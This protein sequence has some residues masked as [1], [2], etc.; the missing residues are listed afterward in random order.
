MALVS[1]S[2]PA[3]IPSAGRQGSHIDLSQGVHQ[4]WCYQRVTYCVP[5]PDVATRQVPIACSSHGIRR[6]TWSLLVLALTG[7]AGGQV[8]IASGVDAGSE[9]Q[10]ATL[11]IK[12][13]GTEKSVMDTHAADRRAQAWVVRW[14]EVQ[15]L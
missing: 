2:A 5:A 3:H 13:M 7:N 8:W 12:V 4:M 15:R 14:C 11:Y 9:Q 1:A 10:R 6:G